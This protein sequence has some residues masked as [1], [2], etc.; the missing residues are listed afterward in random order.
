MNNIQLIYK[1]IK[2]IKVNYRKN[3]IIIYVN[4]DK[5]DSVALFNIISKFKYLLTYRFREFSIII[6]FKNLTFKDKITYLVLDAIIYDLLKRSKFNINIEFEKQDDSNIH[7]S[8]FSGTSLYRTIKQHRYIDKNKFIKEY[9]QAFYCDNTTYRRVISKEN[10]KNIETPSI[11]GSEVATVLKAYSNDE[12]WI[13]AL[14]E[15][16]SELVCNVSSHTEGDCL[17]DINFSD[18]IENSEDIEEKRY[19]MVNIAVINYSEYRLF[20]KIKDNIKNKMYNHKDPLYKRVYGAYDKHKKLFDTIYTEDDFFLITVFQ[21]HVTSRSFKSGNSGT[22]LTRLIENIIGKAKTDYSYV[23]SGN[24]ILFFITR[25]LTMSDDRFI[26]FNE[27][28]D[29]FS[30]GPSKNTIGKSS[31]FIP[32]TIYNLLLIRDEEN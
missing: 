1:N 32:G 28:R 29:Y 4:R 17:L 18:N 11:I 13:D 20:D 27:E 19:T 6:K 22:G 14:S 12:E 5:I 30:Y 9:E 26:G 21:N 8:G 2:P 16:A 7:N 10:L 25:Y 24:N 15:V 3:P 23:L 31:L